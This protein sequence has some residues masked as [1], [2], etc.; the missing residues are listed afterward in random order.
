MFRNTCHV[1][2][3]KKATGY[4]NIPPRMIK[5]CSDE[6]C[7]PFS[8][9]INN[10][11]L[12]NVFPDDL[13]N[14]EV[15]PIHKKNNHLH[16]ENYRPVSVLSSFSKVFEHQMCIQLQIYFDGILNPLVAAYRKRY[17]CQNVLLDFIDKWRMALDDRQY[18]G[19]LFMDLSKCFDCMPHALLICKLNA[20]GVSNS[21]CKMLAS[22]L[23]D[24]KQRTKLGSNKSSWTHLFKGF[25]QGSGL[26]PFLFNVFINDLFLFIMRCL[27]CNYADDNT[28]TSCNKDPDILLESLKTDAE[29]AIQ[30]FTSNMMKANPDK[31]Q[32]IFLCPP[33][34]PDPFQDHFIVSNIYIKRGSSAKLLGVI[35]DDKLCFDKHVTNICCKAARQLNALLRL[36]NVI[37]I[38]QRRLIYQSFIMSNFNYCPLVWHFCSKKSINKIV[39]NPR[40]CIKIIM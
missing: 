35:I 13:K 33:T 23:S 38:D 6:L 5:I 11:I 37:T 12:Q 39:K 26:G 24:R 30:W 8:R 25:P 16:K 4:D 2:I 14:A 29:R 40:T 7:A 10:C 21:T 36:R 22:Y 20:Y 19:T 31:F 1:L 18:V 3:L 34:L 9:I 32:T 27:L 28:L 15:A 17:S